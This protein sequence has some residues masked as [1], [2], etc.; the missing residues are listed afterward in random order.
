MYALV[1]RHE[2]NVVECTTV[3]EL[4][5]VRFSSIYDTILYTIFIYLQ[6]TCNYRNRLPGISF[7]TEKK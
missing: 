3:S 2:F 5:T 6:I 1:A 4:V 7:E